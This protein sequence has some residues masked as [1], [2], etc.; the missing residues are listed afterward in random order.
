[1]VRKKHNLLSLVPYGLIVTRSWL[2]GQGIERHTADNWLKSGKLVAVARGVFKRPDTELTWQGVV[3]SLQRMHG[4]LWLTPGGLTALTEF[5]MAHYISSAE[6][7][8]IHL[9]GQQ[10]LPAWINDI[11]FGTVFV[12]HKEVVKNLDLSGGLHLRYWKSTY[13]AYGFDKLRIDFSS[14]ELSI[15]EV[16]RDVPERI[17]FEHAD[18]LM[19]GLTTLSP[20]LLSSLLENCSSVKVKRLF[21][22][23]AERNQSPWLKKIDMKKF[24]IKNGTLGSGKRMIATGGKLDPKYLITVPKNMS[25]A[26]G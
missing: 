15:L 14:P 22:W 18:L 12:R 23:L 4:W 9:Y 10:P 1:M 17:S 11:L 26:L 6:Q 19:Q 5:G 20:R 3:C 8:I 25:E 7:K 21:F 2:Q 16:L 24:N 13:Y